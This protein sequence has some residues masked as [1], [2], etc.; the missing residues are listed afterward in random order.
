MA[1]TAIL[2]AAIWAPSSQAQLSHEVT[3][4]TPRRIFFIHYRHTALEKS[5][6]VRHG[7]EEEIAKL[8]VNARVQADHI[9]FGLGELSGQK[10][11]AETILLKSIR[12]WKPH[13][14]IV[15]GLPSANAFMNFN[16]DNFASW[17]LLFIATIRTPE[18]LLESY[19]NS[20]AILDRFPLEENLELARTLHPDADRIIFIGT[21]SKQENKFRFKMAEELVKNRSGGPELL[22]MFDTPANDLYRD[23][24]DSVTKD[25]IIDLKDYMDEQGKK[26][27]VDEF[28]ST[29]Q[30][31]KKPVPIYSFWPPTRDYKITGGWFFN[32]KNKGRKAAPTAAKI[33]RQNSARGIPT[34]SFNNSQP[35]FF[36]SELDRHNIKKTALPEGSVIFNEPQLLS[37]TQWQILIAGC[38]FIAGLLLLVLY[39]LTNIQ[40]LRA[41]EVKV[42]TAKDDAERANRVK[43]RFLANMSHEIRTPMNAILGFSDILLR[44]KM[45]PEQREYVNAISTSGKTLMT[46]INDILD[47]SKIESGKIELN[48]HKARTKAV[49]TETQNIFGLAAEK[50][51]LAFSLD[52]D[53]RI[54]EFLIFDD[55]RLRQVIFNLV[56]N[57]IKFT[58]KGSIKIAANWQEGD[59]PK[60]KHSLIIRVTDTG[61]GIDPK[62]ITAIFEEFVQQEGQDSRVYGGTGLGLS[63]S[64]RLVELMG[65]SLSVES[66][67]GLGS[68]FTLDIRD[69]E[70][71]QSIKTAAAAEPGANSDASIFN[72]EK[73]LLAEDNPL[74]QKLVQ[75]Y[76]KE[77]NLDISVADDGQKALAA[78]RTEH[79]TL[80]I[81][82]LEMPEMDG[83]T[84][85]KILRSEDE[86]KNLPILIVS[87]TER[88]D[89]QS[90][91]KK[92]NLV[93]FAQ[94]P[95]TKAQLATQ[96][97]KI[98][99]SRPSEVTPKELEP[100]SAD[101]KQNSTKQLTSRQADLFKKLDNDE[102]ATASS[103]RD[104]DYIST[105]I[106]RLETLQK[107]L[108]SD[109][110][111]TYIRKYRAACDSFDV[112]I[113]DKAQKDFYSVL[114]KAEAQ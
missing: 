45:Q 90:L 94:K 70:V 31:K 93:G 8:G 65:G 37:T 12:D 5:E 41:A 110:F 112:A 98:L 101:I 62:S 76:G 114:E 91:V 78:I 106:D 60:R 43:T 104:I 89:S 86:T 44:K 19:P 36:W 63:I 30:A 67:P 99:K 57:A 66:S 11:I 80:A 21:S 29:M 16:P 14:I 47:L 52:W 40:K 51:G 22:T 48:K 4:I 3:D 87:A 111:D 105:H 102:L 10:D 53:D 20:T 74:N 69:I 42:R 49:F 27:F 13:L 71:D 32:E 85:I 107:Q 9:R 26:V 58:N 84:A 61:I 95:I 38:I 17:P 64:K 46:L 35:M 75:E 92:Y 72:Q 23:I 59:A 77:L 96:L 83:L 28:M 6:D 24:G 54:P 73:V 7:L 25:V 109:I 103:C 56:G 15:H 33:L 113:L 97:D 55:V 2:S 68:T 18:R 79:P 100:N 81:F 108:D 88:E 34:Q 39:L 1:L 82:D 50:K